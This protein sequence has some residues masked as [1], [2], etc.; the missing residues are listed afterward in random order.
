MSLDSLNSW[1][2]EKLKKE[3]WED[4]AK[5]RKGIIRPWLV[6]HGP[7]YIHVFM[8]LVCYGVVWV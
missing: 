4:P 5:V 2:D 8:W 7:F 6:M 3:W 1:K